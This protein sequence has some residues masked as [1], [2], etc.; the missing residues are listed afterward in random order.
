MS[1]QVKNNIQAFT[2]RMITSEL[3]L[4]EDQGRQ[5]GNALMHNGQFKSHGIDQGSK[6]LNLIGLMLQDSK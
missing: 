4:L 2:Q 3:G 6:L 1:K 5:F